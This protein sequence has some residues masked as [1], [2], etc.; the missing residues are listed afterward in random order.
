MQMH[1]LKK[2][3]IDVDTNFAEVYS[4]RPD[5]QI[6]NISLIMDWHQTVGVGGAVKFLVV[7][8]IG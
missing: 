4:H 3:K 8:T 5:G 6:V 1:F 7:G 2:K